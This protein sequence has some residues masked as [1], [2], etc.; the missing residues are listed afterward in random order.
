MELATRS[1]IDAAIDYARDNWKV[2]PVYADG[3]RAKHPV[4]LDWVARASSDPAT[5]EKLFTEL[6]ARTSYGIGLAHGLSFVFDIDGDAGR[7]SLAQVEATC[8]PL[9]RECVGSTPRGGIHIAVAHPPI[10]LRNNVGILKGLDLR[11]AGSQTLAAPTRVTY[12]KDGELIDGVYAWESYLPATQLPTWDGW[13][14]FVE[15]FA[16]TVRPDDEEEGV[17]NPDAL[18][19]KYTEAGSVPAGVRNAWITSAAGLLRQ[20]CPFP[21]EG[22]FEAALRAMYEWGVSE[23]LRDERGYAHVA[24]LARR[25]IDKCPPGLRHD[26]KLYIPCPFEPWTQAWHAIKVTA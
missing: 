20:K 17:A 18:Y 3:A 4:G 14:K 16:E 10:K 21:S 19:R 22:I 11:G 25:N 9:P 24:D 8:G 23:D 2:I 12:M 7:E 1:I 26:G 5:V 6:T 15:A 13:T